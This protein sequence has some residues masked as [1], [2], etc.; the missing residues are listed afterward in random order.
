MTKV[1][2]GIQRLHTAEQRLCWSEVLLYELRAHAS[3]ARMDDVE[4]IFCSLL[5]HLYSA[6]ACIEVGAKLSGMV[7]FA[8]GFNE[9][10][11]SDPLLIYMWRARDAVAHDTIIRWDNH[12]HIVQITVVDEDKAN[13]IP[14]LFS[15]LNKPDA[16]VQDLLAYFYEAK[17]I[18]ELNRK[19]K[20]NFRP[21][22]RAMET[23][24]VKLVYAAET[25][26]LDEFSYRAKEQGKKFTIERPTKHLGKPIPA[27]ADAASDHTVKFYRSMLSAAKAILRAS[28]SPTQPTA[29]Q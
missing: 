18:E 23:S 10:C 15:T 8:K 5:H 4:R 6:R 11:L 12:G 20:E 17:N 3:L 19:A 16:N 14:R 21:S 9:S 7:G 13:A 28:L 24:G 1:E 27:N 25:I 26:L 2:K 29:Q 22:E